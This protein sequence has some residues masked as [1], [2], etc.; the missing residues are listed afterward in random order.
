MSIA[1]HGPNDYYDDDSFDTGTMIAGR[2]A[3]AAAFDA[4]ARY[5]DE[6]AGDLSLD[7]DVLELDGLL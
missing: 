7:D 5:V 2:S 3:Q 1:F 6:I 4:A